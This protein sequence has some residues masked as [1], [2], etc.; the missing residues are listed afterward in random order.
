VID[1]G[2]SY[3]DLRLF[4]FKDKLHGAYTV[5]RADH[6]NQ[7]KGYQAYGEIKEVD[8]N[9]SIEHIQIRRPG[10]DF[11]GTEKNWVLFEL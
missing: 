11:T 4:L 2:F 5:S 7:F 3:E 10:N 8:G 1:N 6:Q 9:W